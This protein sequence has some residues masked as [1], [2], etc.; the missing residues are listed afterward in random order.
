M[1]F[2]KICFD[3]FNLFNRINQVILIILY[4]YV[5]LTSYLYKV[6]IKIKFTYINLTKS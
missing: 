5:Y 6:S 2:L 3:L 1:Q 4:F